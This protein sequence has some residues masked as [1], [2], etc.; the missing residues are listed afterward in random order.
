MASTEMAAGDA[1]NGSNTTSTTTWADESAQMDGSTQAQG[2]S[3]QM[4]GSTQVQGGS[5]Q[6]VEPE[7]DVEVKLIDENSPLYSVKSFAELGL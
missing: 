1:N 3:D 4:D 6:M 7:Y 5:D 2:G